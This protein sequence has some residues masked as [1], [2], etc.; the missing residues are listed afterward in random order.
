VPTDFKSYNSVPTIVPYITINLD[1]DFLKNAKSQSDLDN[2]ILLQTQGQAVMLTEIYDLP[3]LMYI[4]N[5][6][7]NS[8]S[9]LVFITKDGLKIQIFDF[10]TNPMIRPSEIITSF[11]SL[12]YDTYKKDLR[13]D[14]KINIEEV[15][16]KEPISDVTKKLENCLNLISKMVFKANKVTLIGREPSV[17]FLLTQI[18]LYPRIRELWYQQDFKSSP[19]RIYKI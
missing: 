4:T 1:L 15:W 8:S 17:L 3:S 2:Y 10:S 9:E 18:M 16:S 19:I 6:I 5:L 13:D 12:V 11:S 7:H 14:I